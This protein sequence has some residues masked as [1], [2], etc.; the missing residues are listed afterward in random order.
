VSNTTIK[1]ASGISGEIGSNKE[2]TALLVSTFLLRIGFASSLIL[3]DWQ[4]VWGIENTLGLDA[5]SDFGPIFLTAFASVTFLIA[6]IFLTGYYGHRSDR[7]G[8]KPIILFATFG[9]GFVLL[10]YSPSSLLLASAKD[11][12]SNYMSLII[13]VGYLALIHFLHGV[14][15]SAKVSPTLGYINH[16]STDHNRSLRM[17]Y[18][19]NAVL[20]GRAVGMPFG[21]LLWFL[22][23]VEDDGISVDEQARRIALAYPILTLI[24]VIATL[25]IIFGIQNTPEQEEVHPFSIKEDIILAAQVMYHEDRKPLL[26]PWLALASIIGSVSLWGPSIA[27][28]TG[29]ESEERALEALIPVVVIVVALALPAPLWGWYA[30]RHDRRAALNIGIAG[31]PVIIIGALIGFPF[32]SD[33]ISLSNIYLLLSVVPGVMLFSALVPVMMGALGDTAEHGGHED[34]RV[35]SGYHFIIATG[36]VIGIL[37]GGIFI[38][39]FAFIQSITEW[40]GEGTDGDGNALLIGFL[41]FEVIL[42]ILVVRGVMKIPHRE[43]RD[44]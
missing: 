9:A 38:G 19:D 23:G 21:G 17:A 5:V 20:Y 30:D 15:A 44:D 28:R 4:L 36:E 6:E 40:F 24:L 13:M 43:L 12:Y 3:F 8:V 7:R 16:F 22:L 34:G 10:L 11:N 18:Y 29:G 26:I 39:V 37:V 25:F 35:M 31:L 41:L 14:V 27:F 32:Y 42:I 33:D 2:L 1:S